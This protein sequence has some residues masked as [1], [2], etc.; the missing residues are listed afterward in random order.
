M[1][2][3]LWVGVG[4]GCGALLLLAVVAVAVGAY[5]VKRSFGGFAETAKKAKAQRVALAQLDQQFPFHAP[6]E[7]PLVLNEGRLQE[8]LAIRSDTLAAYQKFEAAADALK[9]KKG[10]AKMSMSDGLHAAEQLTSLGVDVEQHYID[11]LGQHHMSPSEFQEI[12]RVAYSEPDAQSPNAALLA[13]FKAQ[14]EQ[15]RNAGL[16]GLLA[17]DDVGKAIQRDLRP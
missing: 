2:K 1:A 15:S 3:K 5:Y 13:R 10:D 6:A 4:I 11:D 9:A 12:S 17:S 14:V 16:D 8:Y 7:G